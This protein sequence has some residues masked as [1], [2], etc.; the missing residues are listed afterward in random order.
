MSVSTLLQNLHILIAL[1]SGIGFGLRGYVRLIMNRPLTVPLLRIG[2]HVADTLLLAS[3]IALWILT[4]LS[5][6]S[7][8]GF[9]LLLV[10]AYI[11]LGIRAFRTAQ[12]WQ[13]ILL[14]LAALLM[15]LSAAVASA[16]KPGL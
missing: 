13:A 10:A 4:G 12:A 9:K 15:F 7:W 8:F 16:L 5:L 2:P 11:G 1:A 14:Y 3:G 6:W